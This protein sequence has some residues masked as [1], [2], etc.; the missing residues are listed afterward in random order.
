[1]AGAFESSRIIWSSLRT[2][3][4]CCDS[5]GSLIVGICY[6]LASSLFTNRLA[7]ISNRGRVPG[8]VVSTAHRM[9]MSW[10]MA[11]ASRCARS[12]DA[13]RASTAHRVR[14]GVEDLDGELG[15]VDVDPVAGRAG[16]A[17]RADLGR[18]GMVERLDAEL[19][20]DP[21]PRRG[22]RGARLAG[23]ARDAEL[24]VT[25][26]DPFLAGHLAEPERVRRRRHQ[27][28]RFGREDRGGALGTRHGRTGDAQR[29]ELLGAGESRPETDER[30]EREGE[31]DPVSPRHAGGA[32]DRL[33]AVSPPLPRLG[34]VQH[35]ERPAG[36][37]ARLMDPDVTVERVGEIRS[38]RRMRGSILGELCLRGERKIAEGACRARVA[39]T[40]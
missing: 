2:D 39:D 1:M 4:L 7:F 36:R 22:D 32:I 11:A 38:E 30:T 20:F 19:A 16:D 31:E 6:A 37:A 34:G 14:R 25:Q 33:P 27:H 17:V 8:A 21:L 18:A 10:W 28:R 12:L 15:L 5:S 26:V 29:P 24:G 40:R 13:P 3:S 23:V 35:P 9:P